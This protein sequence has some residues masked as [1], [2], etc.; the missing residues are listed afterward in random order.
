MEASPGWRY[1]RPGK[2]SSTRSSRSRTSG[3]ARKPRVRMRRSFAAPSRSIA[4]SAPTTPAGWSGTLGVYS[5]ELTLPG[6]TALPAG[7]VT[8]GGTLPTHRRR[9]ILRALHESAAGGHG[10]ARRTALRAP[11]IR[12]QHLPA[13]RLTAPPPRITSFSIDRAYAGFASPCPE[14]RPARDHPSGR[15]GGRGAAGVHLRGLAPRSTGR[16]EQIIRM[17]DQL[18]PGPGRANARAPPRCITRSMPARTARPMAT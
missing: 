1:V 11:G 9:G 10:P 13:L 5:L 4:R 18:P 12:S 3:S 16:G 8:W 17:V 2:K 7:G 14:R 15:R 6:R